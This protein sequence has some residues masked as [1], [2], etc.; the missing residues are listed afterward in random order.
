MN[1]PSPCPTHHTIQWKD[2]GVSRKT[3]KTY[4]G[5]WTCGHKNPD[6]TWCPYNPDDASMVTPPGTV[7]PAPASVAP[8]QQSLPSQHVDR[9]KSITW[10]N[11]KNNAVE[12]VAAQLQLPNN[13]TMTEDAMIVLIQRLAT[14]I[15]TMKPITVPVA[16]QTETINIEDIPF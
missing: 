1:Q 2:G 3:G 16:P 13:A 8:Q 4:P 11:A 15:Y 12:L 5:F 9:E 6:G 7:S 10:L 14:K